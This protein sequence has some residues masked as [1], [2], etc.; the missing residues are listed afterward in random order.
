MSPANRSTPGTAVATS[1]GPNTMPSAAP[2]TTSCREPRRC[3]RSPHT[4]P[5]VLFEKTVYGEG[6]PNDLALNLR[7]RVFQQYDGAGVVTNMD[8]DDATDQDQAY[9]FKGNLLRST[10]RLAKDYTA[11]TG[12][13]GSR[14]LEPVRH[15]PKRTTYDALNRP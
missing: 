11:V 5:K 8:H 10:R 2:C 4:R 12:L 13:E 1:S 14:D 9:D 7:T 6:Q 3:L 15:L